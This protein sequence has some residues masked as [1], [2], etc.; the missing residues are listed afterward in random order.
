VI[1]RG[2]GLPVVLVPGIPGR[3]EW[4]AP[5]VDA[6]A[7]RCR[8]LAFSFCDEPTSGFSFDPRRG[9]ENY[10]SQIDDVLVRAGVE[11]ALLVGVSYGGLV[12]AEFAARY[13][14]RVKG[15]VLV[16]SLPVGWTPDRRARFYMRAPRL[17]SPLFF[18]AAPRRLLPEIKAAFPSIR[19]RFRFTFQN[20]L[21]VFRACLSPSR[22][23]RRVE[24]L[25][26]HRFTSLSAVQAPTLVVTGEDGLDR[27]V[28]PELSRRCL[29][30]LPGAR[31]TVLSGTGHIGLV[32][33]PDAFAEVVQ[34]F[35]DEISNDARRVSA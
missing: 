24:W 23:S 2:K 19:D 22:M 34:Q 28:A 11:N 8:V 13:P 5:A 10:L 9:L 33:R 30:E 12:A 16:S 18:V 21:R 25:A 6:L 35:A 14:G 17:L 4:M 1:D 3:W 7:E 29:D 26:A 32:T 15:L 31:T 27:V 20:G